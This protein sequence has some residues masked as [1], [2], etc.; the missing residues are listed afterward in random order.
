MPDWLYIR[1]A[2]LTINVQTTAQRL[3]FWMNLY[4]LRY[5]WQIK[6]Y[7]LMSI[8][9]NLLW[10]TVGQYYTLGWSQISLHCSL[11]L[12]SYPMVTDNFVDSSMC[13]KR[14]ESNMN[15]EHLLE[16]ISQVMLNV[17]TRM[18]CEAWES[19]FTFTLLKRTKSPPR[20][21][22]P[23]GTYF[24]SPGPTQKKKKKVFLHICMCAQT[25]AHIPYITQKLT[26]NY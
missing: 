20:V 6:P 16:T 12:I 7:I 24:Q 19:L 15:P 10:E 9:V 8:V 21:W 3:K 4:E 2:G 13:S 5:G 22:K 1:L 18:Q 14:M 25:H 23:K 26:Q 11:H 17:W